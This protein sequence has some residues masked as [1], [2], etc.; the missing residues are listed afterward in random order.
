M[1]WIRGRALAG[2]P[3]D[4]SYTPASHMMEGEDGLQMYPSLHMCSMTHTCVVI[5]SPTYIK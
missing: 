4:L 1:G 5:H 2:K 3:D